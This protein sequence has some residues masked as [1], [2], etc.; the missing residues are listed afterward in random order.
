[1]KLLVEDT[2]IREITGKLYLSA[3]TIEPHR[4]NIMKKLNCHSAIELIR[5][6]VRIG[7]IDIDKRKVECA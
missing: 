3:K 6:T 4:A 1:M 7:L 2:N 5:Y